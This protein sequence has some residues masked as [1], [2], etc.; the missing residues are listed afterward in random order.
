MNSDVSYLK[1]I[2]PNHGKSFNIGTVVLPTASMQRIVTSIATK[3]TQLLI[4]SY[5]NKTTFSHHSNSED[6][7]SADTVV[8]AKETLTALQK[9]VQVTNKTTEKVYGGDHGVLEEIDQAGQNLLIA[10][11]KM[12]LTCQVPVN[13]LIVAIFQ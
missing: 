2:I 5:S 9:L 11:E 3:V 8:Y 7:S 12:L 6:P 1:H 10:G 4:G 13:T